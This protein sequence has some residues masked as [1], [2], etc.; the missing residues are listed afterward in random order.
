[1]KKKQYQKQIESMPNYSPSNRFL[2][3]Q[4]DNQSEFQFKLKDK[5]ICFLEVSRNVNNGIKKAEDINTL[6]N[7]S[8]VC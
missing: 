3:T 5:D 1:M 7:V 2:F 6:L 8:G 4:I